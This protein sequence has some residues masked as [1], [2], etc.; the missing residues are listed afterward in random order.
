MTVR[1]LKMQWVALNRKR[2]AGG[3]GASS[4]PIK[5]MQN[6]GSVLIQISVRPKCLRSY[7][8]HANSVFR[9]RARAAGVMR[10]S[11]EKCPRGALLGSK[12]M[13]DRRMSK[14]RSSRLPWA[15]GER[16]IRCSHKRTGTHSLASFR[17]LPSR[18]GDT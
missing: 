12:G 13:A 16:H 18:N 4:L 9:V 5:T 1:W 17:A 3:I 7:A 8:A 2:F 10:S 14:I 15:G 6:P 11:R